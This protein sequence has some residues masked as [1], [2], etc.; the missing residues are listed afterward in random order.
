MAV[1]TLLTSQVI[2][3]ELLRRFKN[4]L[5]FS[6]A[7]AHTWDDKF[8]VEGAKIGD[9]LR[10]RDP[11]MFVASAGPV[12]SPQ[13]V[14][15]NQKTLQLSNQQ[16][17]GFA[18]T[19]KDLTLS[20]DNFAARYLDS[21]AVA[22][23]NAVD[24]AGLTMADANVP[25][26][27]GTVGTPI[28]TA[29]PFWTAGEM[30]DTSSAPMDGTRSMVI[31]PKIQTAALTTF[32]GLFQSSSQ[33]KQQ[34]ERGRMG[35]MGGFEWVMDQN[36]VTHTN[37]PL[38]GAP[39]VGAANQTGSTLAT[40]GWTAAAAVR[41]NAGDVFTLPSVFRVNRVSGAVKT[42]LQQFTVLANAS[43]DATGAATLSIY[44][45][46]V[47]TMPGQTVSASPAAGAPL[48]IVTG[49]TG[50]LSIQ[51]IAFHKDAFTLGMAPLEVPKNIQFGANQQDPDT[52]CAIRMVSMYDII[53]DLFVTR[54]DVLFGWAATRP[55]WAC[56]VVQ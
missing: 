43:S 17:V 46:I 27:V 37:G 14:V 6:G 51:G 40:T 4:N 10:L 45:P 31:P 21:A 13:N 33:V 28:T 52:G 20:I 19:S 49:T 2:T 50:Q 25:N 9:T 22:L 15:E 5:G 34:Y 56:K 8:A 29:V 11:V 47:T 32:Q 48:T 53:N 54:C 7:V 12:M 3:N 26:L 55:E 36:C 30:L 44:P 18:F 42:D 41:L 24:I 35:I 1:N 23:A 38:G 39:Q 16:V